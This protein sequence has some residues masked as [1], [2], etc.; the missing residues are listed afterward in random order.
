VRQNFELIATR[1]S[2]LVFGFILNLFALKTVLLHHGIG[3]LNLLLIIWSLF[4]LFNILDLGSSIH[5]MNNLK[6]AKSVFVA[7]VSRSLQIILILSFFF[8]L[9]TLLGIQFLHFQSFDIAINTNLQIVAL[10]FWIHSSISLLNTLVRSLNALDE[11]IWSTL[12]SSLLGP[13]TSILTISFVLLRLKFEFLLFSGAIAGLLL[14]TIALYKLSNHIDLKLLK[15]DLW[16]FSKIIKNI[17]LVYF[18]LN[19]LILINS[20][21]PRLI[22]IKSFSPAQAVIGN[23]IFQV[24]SAGISLGASA[25]SRIWREMILRR[26]RPSEILAYVNQEVTRMQK[27]A[28][29]ISGLVFIA[30]LVSLKFLQLEVTTSIVYTLM[31][32]TIVGFIGTRNQVYGAYSS[33]TY[34]IKFQ[35]TLQFASLLIFGLLLLPAIQLTFLTFFLIWATV[36]ITFIHLPIWL[37]F[38]A[39]KSGL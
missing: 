35:I 39:M 3:L 37:R 2:V 12:L 16:N 26:D 8:F 17:N 18:G 31:I 38:R 14:T 36:N 21:M 1:G 19:S 27:V 5:I 24:L 4:P 11:V 23:I 10:A 20:V 22:L 32:V 25:G 6:S 28:I 29:A 13:L 15:S 34:G 9:L 33:D 30:S 7:A